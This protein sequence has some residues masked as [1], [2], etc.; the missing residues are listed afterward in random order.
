MTKLDQL[1]VRVWNSFFDFIFCG[2]ET[3]TREEVQAELRQLGIDVGPAIQKVQHAL[4]R[5]R[6]AQDAR[7]ALEEARLK[8]GSLLRKLTSIKA[9]SGSHIRNVL[10]AMIS[11]R[12]SAPQQEVYARKLEG[13]ASDEDLRSLLEDIARLDALSKDQEDG[14]S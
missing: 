11:E 6:E 9:P 5:A 14:N 3:M 1:D 4:R 10:K 7:T 2:T 8:R 13:A 12:F